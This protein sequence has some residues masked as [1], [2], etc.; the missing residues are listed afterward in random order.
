MA[1][2]QEKKAKLIRLGLNDEFTSIVGT[3]KY[4]RDKY[5]ISAQKIY[6]RTRTLFS[7]L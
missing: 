1:E 2:M 7:N 6:G 5:N 3:Q 4:L